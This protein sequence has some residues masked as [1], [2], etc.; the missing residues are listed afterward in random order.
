VQRSWQLV[1]VFDSFKLLFIFGVFC[2]QQRYHWCGGVVVLSFVIHGLGEF[3]GSR[4]LVRSSRLEWAV[5]GVVD[6]S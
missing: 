4:I 5:I 2:V 1:V 6:K 3:I